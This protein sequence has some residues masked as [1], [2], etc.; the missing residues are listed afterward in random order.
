MILF[1]S[2]CAFLTVLDQYGQCMRIF[3]M[4]KIICIGM[5]SQRN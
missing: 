2:V 1:V 3:D 5:L 4:E